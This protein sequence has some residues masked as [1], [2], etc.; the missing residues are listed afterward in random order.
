ME[1]EKCFSQCCFR[2]EDSTGDPA[3]PVLATCQAICSGVALSI[4]H[5]K[6]LAKKL[7]QFHGPTIKI[8][9]SLL[10]FK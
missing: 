9:F 6:E 1:N 5:I 10:T 8:S 3:Q 7:D 4:R 2:L